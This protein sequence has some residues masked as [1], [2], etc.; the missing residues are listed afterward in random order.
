MKINKLYISAFGGLKDFTL[1]LSDGFNVIYGENENGKSTIAAFIKAMF[2]GT[3]KKTQQ[4]SN[5]LRQ[6]YTPWNSD[7]MGGRIYFEHKG[8]NYCLEREF[9]KSDSTDRIILTNSDSG[10]NINIGENIG[11]AFF[12]VSASAFERSMFIGP[13]GAFSKD[14]DA[15]GELNARL[16]NLTFTGE[17]DVSFRKIAKRLEDAKYRIISRNGKLGS[18][19]RETENLKALELRLQAAEESIHKKNEISKEISNYEA[20]I[21]AQK[22]EYF[23]LKS[24][25]DRENDIRNYGKLKDFIET[26]DSLNAV[27]DELRL[28]DGGI[29]AKPFIAA[30]NFGIT[31][32]EKIS[33][34]CQEISEDIEKIKESI[35]F[36][37]ENSPEKIKAELE[38][39][40]ERT[41]NLSNEKDTLEISENEYKQKLELTQNGNLSVN[42]QKHS[43]NPMLLVPSIII[44]ALTY[45]SYTILGVSAAIITLML[46]AVLLTLSF[47]IPKNNKA[48]ILQLERQLTELN[49]E[50]INIRTKK[51][52]IQEQINNINAKINMLSSEL[53]T[54]TAVRAQRLADLND[55]QEML[56]SQIA[57]QESALDE[58]LGYF[59]RYKYASG[60]DE[61]KECLD[62]LS[63]KTEKQSSL[64]LRQ[65]MLGE[66]LGNISYDEAVERLKNCDDQSISENIDF[67]SVK[68]E[69]ATLNEDLASL[70]DKITA[71]NT[72]LTTA[73]K[74]VENPEDIKR[75][76][77]QSKSSLDAQKAFYD[78]LNLAN[79]VL[80]E[81]FNEVRRGY[82]G[83]VETLTLDIF[84]RLT[85]GRYKSINV[86]KSLD[87]TVESATAFGTREIEYLSQG[88]VEQ[89][90]LSLRLALSR[91]IAKNADLPIILDDSLS[92]YDDNRADTAIK[93]LKEFC[94]DS[95]G[96]LFTCHNSICEIAQKYGIEINTPF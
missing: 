34:R 1:Q 50:I 16:S 37:N 77:S 41:R 35:K 78:S 23:R 83:E 89:A 64:K 67:E 25:I 55:K 32:Y 26:S 58:V 3:G 88:T 48:A 82:G 86:S 30:V 56:N 75:A 27:N 92:Q 57:K 39:L 38:S 68:A 53:N 15:E 90:Y 59:G 46:T 2:Y 52:D 65:T 70:R 74:N 8:T 85:G 7:I 54:D 94:S 76:I 6:K 42:A 20:K 13:T 66:D 40:N 96:L 61:I 84:S 87:M 73:F 19:A 60:I 79:Q 5:S 62:Q 22:S 51:A 47:I 4:L 44:A 17:E 14:A 18:F 29:L 49:S 11:T 69:F 24:I 28:K 72:E 10:E 31:K 43:V 33:S 95:Q 91:L 36:Q 81:S 9:R 80:E 21:E 45:F 12:G 93:F 63:K 71:L